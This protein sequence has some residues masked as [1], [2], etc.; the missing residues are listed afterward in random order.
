MDEPKDGEPEEDKK[1]KKKKKGKKISKGGSKFTPT[2]K[3]FGSKISVNK[4]KGSS[5]VLCGWRCRPEC[6]VYPNS[7]TT[8]PC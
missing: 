1:G 4:F 2:A 5:K 7:F 8:T 6:H 3:N